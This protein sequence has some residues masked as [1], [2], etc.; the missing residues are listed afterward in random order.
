LI[1]SREGVEVEQN[2]ENQ[3]K[4]QNANEGRVQSI[5][6]LSA[7]QNREKEKISVGF[8]AK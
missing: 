2:Q 7:I 6:A 4:Q 5:A 3:E 8:G 1:E